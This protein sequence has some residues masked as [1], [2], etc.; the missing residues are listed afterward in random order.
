V[1]GVVDQTFEELDRPDHRLT[2]RGRKG[3]QRALAAQVAQ[4][5]WH[6]APGAHQVV[7][8]DAKTP[9]AAVNHGSRQRVEKRHRLRQVRSQLVEGERSFLERLEHEGKVELFEIAQP[10]VE[11]LAG[12]ARGAGR[13]VAGV[14]QSHPQA[15]GHS[16]ERTPAASD[17]RTYHQDVKII[18][19]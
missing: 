7:H 19:G 1:P 10:A 9:V 15:P 11:Q 14:D 8:P 16:I 6:S 13:E 18:S 17:A 5:V 2:I 12:P 4:V 3:L